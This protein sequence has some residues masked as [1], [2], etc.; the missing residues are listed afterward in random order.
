MLYGGKYCSPQKPCFA[1]VK[2][3]HAGKPEPKY[4]GAVFHYDYQ[5]VPG[6]TST[7]MVTFDLPI[8]GAANPL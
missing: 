5:R 6:G 7:P 3:N 2:F 8:E 4:E 1:F